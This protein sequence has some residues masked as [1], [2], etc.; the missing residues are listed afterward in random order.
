MPHVGGVVITPRKVIPDVCNDT[1]FQPLPLSEATPA[2]ETLV[3]CLPDTISAD[4][5]SQILIFQVSDDPIKSIPPYNSC[6]GLGGGAI[7]AFG[8]N[9]CM[10]LCGTAGCRELDL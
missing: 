6:A 2:G 10:G 4:V 1:E 8:G 5:A 3:G 7:L 9:H